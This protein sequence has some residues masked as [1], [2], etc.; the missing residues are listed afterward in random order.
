VRKILTSATFG[1]ALAGVLLT[2]SLPAAGVQ[3]RA[4][5]PATAQGPGR[6]LPGRPAVPASSG[7]LSGVFCTSKTNCWAVGEGRSGKAD[8]NQILHWNGRSWR[9]ATTPDPG[10]TAGSADNELYAVRCV[11][12]KNCWAVGQYFKAGAYL[13]EALHWN[14][15]HWRATTV[16]A[17][18]GTGTGD[19]N[20]LSDSTCT[21]ANSCWAVG[22]FG[23]DG[24]LGKTLNLVLHWNGKRWSRSHVPNPGGTKPTD[25]NALNAVR[26]TS[27]SDCD[28]VG[29]WG[30]ATS[31]KD[32]DLNE[33][34]HW[35]GRHWSSVHVPNPGGTGMGIQ[36]EISAL[37]C[38]GPADCW[39]AGFYDT[40]KPTYALRNE[41]LHWN[42]AKW[43]EAKVPNPGAKGARAVNYVFGT[44]CDGPADCWAVGEYEIKNGATL[45]QVLHW[46]GKR[47]YLVGAPN[48]RGGGAFDENYLSAVRCISTANCW[49]V[50]ASSPHLGT[51]SDEILHWNG[52]KWSAS[53]A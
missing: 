13:A 4:V 38:G 10:G 6:L 50:G 12:S 46:N 17:P 48:P 37:A 8:L 5:R 9:Q 21:A 24:M 34:L 3:A 28:A 44:T 18:G 26:C 22:D 40:I 53:R 1:I 35:N 16:P 25:F 19:L 51:S 30:S 43:T 2:I 14:G 23:V 49:A 45:N 36:N 41:M 47:W 11:N 52:K 15:K 7:S 29:Y 27:A 33:A 20:E 31:A 42:G 39:A 32:V